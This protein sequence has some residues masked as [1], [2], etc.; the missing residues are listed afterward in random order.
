VAHAVVLA[1]TKGRS[2]ERYIVN[3]TN[4]GMV[5]FIN[6]VLRVMEKKVLIVPLS[7]RGIKVMDGFLQVLDKVGL[8]PGVRSLVQ[9]NIDKACS[10]EKIREEMNWEPS[11]TLE[12]S[13][14]ASAFPERE[15]ISAADRTD[16]ENWKEKK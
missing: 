9:M 13:V 2:G 11:F 8:N 12:Q 14:R 6:T 1:L 10:T 4:I 5:E 3:A 16:S 15:N 7:N